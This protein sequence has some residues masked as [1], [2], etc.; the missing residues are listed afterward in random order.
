MIISPPFLPP[1]GATQPDQQWLDVAMPAPT[2]RLSDTGAPEGSFPLSHSLSWHNGMHLQAPQGNGS[3]L[4]VRA[5]ADGTVIFASKPTTSNTNVDDP[6][7]YNPFDRPGV[8]TAAWTDNG[9]IIIEHR[10]TIGATGTT[11]TEVVFY[12]LYM[13]LSAL[14]KT[15]PE[16]QTT[17]RAWQAG[18]SI[19]RKDEVGTPGS[20]YGHG[21]Q[22]HFE[23]CLDAAN[24]QH[25]IGRAPS[26]TAPTSRPAPTADGRTDS[27]FGSL[28]FYL[29]TNTAID[30]GATRPAAGIRQSSTTTLGSPLWVKMS[31][32]QGACQFE[33]YNER[34]D[35]IGSTAL[36]ADVEYNLYQDAT[37]RHNTLT[38]AQ[39]ATSSPS[40]WYELLRFGR[41]IGRGTAATDK[42]PLPA[43]AAHWRRIV[44]PAGNQLW[45]DLNAQGS[46]KFSDAD[47]LAIMGWN[48]IDDDTSPNDQR[49]DSDHIKN[50][51]C[52]PDPSNAVRMETSELSKWL[53]NADVQKKLK[54]TICKF[55]SEWDKTSIASRYAFV[56]EYDSFKQIPEA[57]TTLEAH[58]NAISFD[59]LPANYLAANWHMHPKEFLQCM[60]QS[61]WLSRREL[62]QLVPSYVIRKPGSH[63]SPSQGHWEAPAI[64]PSDIF[65]ATHRIALNKALRKF[66]INSPRRVSSFIGNSV[67][68]TAWFRSLKES[69]GNQPDLHTGWYGRGF[70]QLT[71]PNG[72]LA[73]GN[74]NYFRYFRFIG[75]SPHVPP[76][77]QE[78]AWRD[79]IGT[80]SHHAAHSAG[81]YWVWPNKSTPT[82]ANP[83]RPQVDNANRYADALATNL[84]RTI[85][86]AN[87]N[88]VWYYNQSF[89]NC[90]AAVNYPATVGQNPPNMNGLV[91]RS[92]AFVNALMVLDDTTV[93]EATGEGTTEVPENFSRRKIS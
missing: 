14:G 70:L 27:I 47:F 79:E 35:L 25:L 86:T 45:A 53:G 22:I 23:V 6:Q 73:N 17:K 55:P 33:S 83:N 38:T 3:D 20:I 15:T 60:R 28:Y 2:S 29:P 40:G 46:F 81:A 75:R 4:P 41:N 12:S 34:G 37:E 66:C 88:K 76:G 82:A 44:G 91:D 26:W 30:E 57:W 62:L 48:C 68:E 93:F 18:D 1:R 59:G 87:G 78:L 42:D 49:C 10:T 74:N 64:Q 36:A 19:W 21:G 32:A 89:T 80:D 43:D 52:D 69:N 63:N 39:Q 16:G 7:N 31:Y 54:R 24:L 84:R 67:Q 50:L 58:L 11:E 8:K 56:M 9:C 5:I 90:A 13:H 51:I 77:Q 85:S 71:N 65:M 72:A 61:F 92:T